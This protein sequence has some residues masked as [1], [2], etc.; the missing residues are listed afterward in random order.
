MRAP[1]L[2]RQLF[3]FAIL[4][5]AAASWTNARGSPAHTLQPYSLGAGHGDLSI[6]Y[7]TPGQ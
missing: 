2:E 7:L 1:G 3:D 4:P 5:A 6:N